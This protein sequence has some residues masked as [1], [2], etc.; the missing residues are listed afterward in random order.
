MTDFFNRQLH[1]DDL[2]IIKYNSPTTPFI[3]GKI[4]RFAHKS[5]TG[6][7]GKTLIALVC[8]TQEDIQKVDGKTIREYGNKCVK[9][10]YFDFINKFKNNVDN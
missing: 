4:I 9:I 1:I 3:V 7:E 2:V 6:E 5:D 8:N 10:N